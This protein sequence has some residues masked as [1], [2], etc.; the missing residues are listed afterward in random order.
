MS[1]TKLHILKLAEFLLKKKGINGFS[2]NDIATALNVKNAAIHYHFNAKETLVKAVIK[3]NSDRFIAKIIKIEAEGT[4]YV[5]SLNEYLKVFS[6]NI[7][8]DHQIC[9]FGSLG[10]DFFSLSESVQQEISIFSKLIM[11]WLTQLLEEGRKAGVFIFKSQA[12]TMALMIN[13]CMAGALQLTRMS[14]KQ[15]FYEVLHGIY[16]ELGIRKIN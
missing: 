5:G 1:E 14:E 2:Y 9:L 13:S 15:D 7:N 16:I 6:E 3:D 10:S 12:R 4:D 8:E 11:E